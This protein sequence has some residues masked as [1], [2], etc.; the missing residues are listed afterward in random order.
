MDVGDFTPTETTDTTA[1]PDTFTFCGEVFAIPST[2]GAFATIRYGSLMKGAMAQE[3]R[4]IASIRRALTAEARDSANTELAL[5]EIAA[6]A[7]VYELLKSCLG[8]GQ[9]DTFGELADNSGVTLAGLIAVSSD[10]QAAIAARPTRSSPD[11]SG[12]LSTT[13]QNSTGVG[14]GPTE[15]AEAVPQPSPAAQQR[16]AFEAAL[17]PAGV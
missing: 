6:K 14:S 10:I 8:E 7:A 1:E 2:V 15:P 12:G 13:G 3:K 16:A 9:L 4:A 5:A 17:T 11:S